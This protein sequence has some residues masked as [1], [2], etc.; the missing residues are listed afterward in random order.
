MRDGRER[1]REVVSLLL[2]AL[3]RKHWLEPGKTS[4]CTYESISY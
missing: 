3:R 2:L 1:E 4:S